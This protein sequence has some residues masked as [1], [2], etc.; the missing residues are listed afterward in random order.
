MDNFDPER[1]AHFY[2]TQ[3]CGRPCIGTVC[4]G[5]SPAPDDEYVH[6]DDYDQL[7]ALYRDLQKLFSDSIEARSKGL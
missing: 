6:R 4:R 2:D 3:C 1:V 7:R 5:A